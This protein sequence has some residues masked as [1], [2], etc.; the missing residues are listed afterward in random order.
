[1]TVADQI[2]EYAEQH[3]S[4][5]VDEIL[6]VQDSINRTTLQCMLSRLVGEGE[7]VRKTR[8]VYARRTSSSSF[9]V[10]LKEQE[11]AICNL[12]RKALPL[13]SY[14]IYNGET[15]APLQHHVFQ[16][17]ATY[18]EVE[19]DAVESVFHI[20]KDNDF[21]SYKSPTKEMTR[22]YIDLGKAVV[23]IKPLVS[24]SPLTQNNG[25]MVPTLEKLLV[26]LCKDEDFYFL[27]G[28]EETYIMENA[29]SLYDINESRL[30]RYAKRRNI[31]PKNFEL[32]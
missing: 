10:V 20:C 6:T 19:R 11:S 17:N 21:E 13:I 24:E 5:G 30:K 28:V 26:D 2:I 16:N 27:Q 15:L 1:M 18:I 8:G 14:C 3:E 9:Q 29:R 31:D 22:D 32:Q 25:I 7:L 4:F 23:I 12:I